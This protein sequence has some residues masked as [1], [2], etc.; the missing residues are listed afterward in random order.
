MMPR[1]LAVIILLTS[2][3]GFGCQQ[4]HLPD[5]LVSFEGMV[6]V[7][8][9]TLWWVNCDTRIAQALGGGQVLNDMIEHYEQAT[10]DEFGFVFMSF[11]GR[12]EEQPAPGKNT[13]QRVLT[14]YQ[15]DTVRVHYT[16]MP[17]NAY[18]AAGQYRYK[19][20][21]ALSHEIELVLGFNGRAQMNTIDGFQK[22]REPGEWYAMDSTQLQLILNE[23]DTLLGQLDWQRNLSL[24]GD[25]FETPVRLFRQ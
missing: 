6:R 13:V 21:A 1:Y 25:R 24:M 2:V 17:V 10:T 7:K 14:V 5:N 15:L 11:Q 12:M 18:A 9:D 20:T 8:Q 22:F 4:T 19:N 23:R 16:C 3:L